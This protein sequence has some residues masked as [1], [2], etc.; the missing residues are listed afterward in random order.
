MCVAILFFLVVVL[1]GAFEVLS[2]TFSAYLA[3]STGAWS[4]VRGTYGGDVFATR[5]NTRKGK[6]EEEDEEEDEEEED[7]DDEARTRR[8]VAF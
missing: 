3:S 1:L 5:K 8:R 4:N 6:G 7:D 2:G